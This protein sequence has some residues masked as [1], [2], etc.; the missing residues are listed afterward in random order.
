MLHKETDLI[1]SKEV[2]FLHFM[3][4]PS[5]I[6]LSYGMP[7]FV[8]IGGVRVKLF[9]AERDNN[10]IHILTYAGDRGNVEYSLYV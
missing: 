8:I 2:S 1:S 9:D 4:S 10:G 7:D 3:E 6:I 5:F